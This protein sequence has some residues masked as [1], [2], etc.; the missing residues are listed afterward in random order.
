M[1][2]IG[3]LRAVLSIA[4]AGCVATCLQYLSDL[5]LK[6]SNGGGARASE[7]CGTCGDMAMYVAA[8]KMRRHFSLQFGDVCERNEM[9]QHAELDSPYSLRRR[10]RSSNPT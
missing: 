7:T 2:N 8:G 5:L 1:L 6:S 9:I 4:S 3:T 10:G